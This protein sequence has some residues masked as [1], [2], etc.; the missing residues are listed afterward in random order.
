M[1]LYCCAANQSG[2]SMGW[3]FLEILSHPI[4]RIPSVHLFC[5]LLNVE[6][7]VNEALKKIKH[8]KAFQTCRSI[9]RIQDPQ[10]I[11]TRLKNTPVIGVFLEK[12]IKQKRILKRILIF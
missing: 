3:N 8:I 1:W 10:L 4:R 11:G 6:T 7:I 9:F 12:K 5:S 2:L